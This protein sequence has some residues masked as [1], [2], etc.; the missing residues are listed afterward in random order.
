MPAPQSTINERFKAV[1]E[2]CYKGNVT[3][4]AKATFVKR[5]TLATIIAD[6][7]LPSFDVIRKIAEVSTPRIS[8]EWLIRGIG[9]MLLED[10]CGVT[11][12][13]NQHTIVG[14]NNGGGMS[15]NFVKGLLDEKDKQIARLMAIIENTTK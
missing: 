14:S 10:S 6:D 7:S 13:D 3:A 1:A 4:M 8:M 2:V 15:E 5:S 11:V 9:N 12:R